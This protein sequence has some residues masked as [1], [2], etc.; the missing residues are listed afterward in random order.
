MVREKI[1]AAAAARFVVI[2]D[3]SKY[4]SQLRG[5]I[6]VEVIAFGS[7]RTVRSLNERTSLEFSLRTA[8][9]GGLVTTDNGNLVADSEFIDVQDPD[10]LAEAI[11]GIPGVTGHGLFLGMT[12]VALV[13]HSDGTVEQLPAPGDT[14]ALGG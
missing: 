9:D 4:S 12:D 2:V 5:R 13:G 7:A 3:D 10:A 1:V 14:V 11:S 8:A 6:P